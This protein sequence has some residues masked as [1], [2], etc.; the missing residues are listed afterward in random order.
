MSSSDILQKF[1]KN[2]I[3]QTASFLFTSAE[4]L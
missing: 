1:F 2:W 4:R 3:T